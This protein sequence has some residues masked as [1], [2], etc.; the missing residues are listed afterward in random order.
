MTILL[1][2]Y[3][4]EAEYLALGY[5]PWGR[6]V[7]EDASSPVNNSIRTTISTLHTSN[8]SSPS[9][10]YFLDIFPCLLL[11]ILF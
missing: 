11:F 7:I 4:A 9:N 3:R 2:R 10:N 5:T 1:S 8:T 6:V